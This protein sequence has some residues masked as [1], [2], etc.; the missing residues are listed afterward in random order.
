MYDIYTKDQQRQH[1]WGI[2][3]N[4]FNGV[5][6]KLDWLIHADVMWLRC[7]SRQP[8]TMLWL[9]NID[10]KM[11]IFDYEISEVQ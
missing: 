9:L 11:N 10:I 5:W 6:T 7:I 4:L 2:T 3:S 8:L 1:A